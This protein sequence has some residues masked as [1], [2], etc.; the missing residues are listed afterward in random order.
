VDFELPF[1][2]PNVPSPVKL[3]RN[4]LEYNGLPDEPGLS[5]EP[6]VATPVST[7]QADEREPFVYGV[8]YSDLFVLP[9]SVAESW[10][11]MNRALETCETWGEL[12]S[13]APPYLYEETGGLKG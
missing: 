5:D 7:P 2:W 1:A 3:V 6:R 12:K 13:V 10:S 9:R 4:Y 8:I 11:R